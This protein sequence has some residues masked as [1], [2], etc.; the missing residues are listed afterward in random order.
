MWALIPMTGVLT[1]RSREERQTYRKE[2]QMKM[3]VEIEVMHLQG[4]EHQGL[5]ATTRN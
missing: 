5:T 4:K 2:G 3:G 1:K